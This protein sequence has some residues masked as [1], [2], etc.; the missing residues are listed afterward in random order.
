[1]NLHAFWM[2][3]ILHMA[4]AHDVTSEHILD[5]EV[6]SNRYGGLEATDQAMQ[7]MEN[8]HSVRYP[9]QLVPFSAQL[10]M[11]SLHSHI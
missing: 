11:K 2:A 7:I 1:M 4:V 8:C 5:V 9:N 10:E 3:L 6:S